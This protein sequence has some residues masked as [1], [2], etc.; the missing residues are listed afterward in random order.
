MSELPVNKSGVDHSR[1]FEP[2]PTDRWL[3]FR[4][5][6][7]DVLSEAEYQSCLDVVRIVFIVVDLGRKARISLKFG[8]GW[9]PMGGAEKVLWALG[10]SLP[11][12]READWTRL[13]AGR[14]MEG[15]FQAPPAPGARNGLLAARRYS[16]CQQA[17]LVSNS[18]SPTCFAG[19]ARQLP[20][21]APHGPNVELV[22]ESLT[23][24]K[25]TKRR[26]ARLRGFGP[27]FRDIDCL[28]SLR[29]LFFLRVLA[30]GVAVDGRIA[31]EAAKAAGEFDT[32]VREGLFRFEPHDEKISETRVSNYWREFAIQI[33]KIS[34]DLG[35]LLSTTRRTKTGGKSF[36]IALPPGAILDQLG[37]IS[38]LSA[39]MRT[40]RAHRWNPG[41]G[42]QQP[43]VKGSSRSR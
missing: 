12:P 35:G 23:K 20:S 38:D 32:W 15:R 30:N 27:R 9:V 34:S 16:D 1:R 31:V 11:L 28:I 22:L 25:P 19:Q 6:A 40:E 13:L 3:R 26:A 43:N 36:A 2:F 10:I 8:A 7:V 5:H 42:V 29:A 18:D 33:D 17:N 39:A 14:S 21:P 24:R 41:H 37:S 4:F